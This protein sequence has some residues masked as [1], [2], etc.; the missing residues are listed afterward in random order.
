MSTDRSN[1][2]FFLR[3]ALAL[4]LHA[5]ILHENLTHCS[6]ESYNSILKTAF[7]NFLSNGFDLADTDLQGMS[8]P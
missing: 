4:V 8:N 1:S 3:Q 7:F 2:F 6:A 5:G